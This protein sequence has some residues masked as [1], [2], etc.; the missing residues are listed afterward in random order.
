MRGRHELVELQL[1]E[2]AMFRGSTLFT[3]EQ[4]NPF[5]VMDGRGFR[6]LRAGSEGLLL[7]FHNS[8][9]RGGAPM[10]ESGEKAKRPLEL[11]RS[12]LDGMEG[13]TVIFGTVREQA[14]RIAV[15]ALEGGWDRRSALAVE[16]WAIARGLMDPRS[17]AARALYRMNDANC[18]LLPVLRRGRKL[19]GD[20]EAWLTHVLRTHASAEPPATG[21]E[22]GSIGT[23]PADD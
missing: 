4:L 17:F 13:A 14:R 16:A 1:C 3:A 8:M 7:L 5:M 22:E 11:M 6:R 2:R 15:A 19:H 18:S 20:T 23:D 21:S 12:D 9:R 10:L